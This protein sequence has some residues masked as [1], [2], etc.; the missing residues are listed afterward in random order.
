MILTWNLDQQLNL[1]RKKIDDDVMSVNCDFIV[2]FPIYGQFATIRKPNSRAM[3]YKAYIFI[4]S[5]L[6]SY[7]TWKQN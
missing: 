7:K 6:L 4:N 5:K 2:F 3:V 1:T